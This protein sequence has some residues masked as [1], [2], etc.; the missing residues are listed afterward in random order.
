MN[1]TKDD[2]ELQKKTRETSR[3]PGRIGLQTGQPLIHYATAAQLISTGSPPRSK[4]QDLNMQI[5]GCQKQPNEWQDESQVACK[6]RHMC[7]DK[8]ES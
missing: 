2:H 3:G 7:I 1:S 6:D 4:L 5:Q 8:F